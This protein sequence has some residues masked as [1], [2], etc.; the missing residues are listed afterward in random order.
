MIRSISI[1]EFGR[2]INS[3]PSL[4]AVF[5]HAQTSP[6]SAV[7]HIMR[8]TIIPTFPSVIMLYDGESGILLSQIQSITMRDGLYEIVCGENEDMRETVTI[9]SGE[10]AVSAP[11]IYA[12]RQVLRQ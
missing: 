10:C 7:I 5:Q 12:R 2:E 1:E 11:T 8:A 3:R 6:V 9:Y 4:Y